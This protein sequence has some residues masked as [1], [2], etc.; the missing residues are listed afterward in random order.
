MLTIRAAA[1]LLAR[2]DSLESVRPLLRALGFEAP[3]HVVDAALR[4]ALALGDVVQR[5]RLVAGAGPLRALLAQL[6]DDADPREAARRIAHVLDRHA[7]GAAWLLALVHTPHGGRGHTFTLA[8]IGHASGGAADRHATRPRGPALRVQALRVQLDHVTDSDAD[9]LRAMVDAPREDALLTYARWCDLLGRDALSARFYRA[10]ERAVHTLGASAQGQGTGEERRTLALLTTSRLLFLSFL[11]AKGWLD[12]DRSFLLRE[13]TRALEAGGQ[14]HRRWLHP[15]CFGTLNTPV[16]QR[17]AAAQRFGRVP[18]LNGGLF[19]R[20]PLEGRLRT[21]TFADDALVALVGDVLD[22]YHFTAHEQASGWSE[23]AIDPEMLGR[24]FESLMVPAERRGSGTYYTPPALVERVVADALDVALP[25]GGTPVERRRRLEGLR[26]LDPACGS[27]AFLVH[28][29]ERLATLRIAAGDTRPIHAVRYAVLTESIFGVDRNPVAVWLCEL[30]LWLAVVLE[31]DEPDPLRVA[32]LPNLD[33]H[34]RVGDSLTGGDFRFSPAAGRRLAALRS[35]YVQAVGARKARLAEALDREERARARAELAR[36]ITHDRARRLTLLT[37]MR[38]RDLF[39]ERVP[40]SHADRLHLAQL[41]TRLRDLRA[42]DRRLA[43]GGALPFRFASHMADV[44]QQGGFDLVLGNPPWVRPHQLPVAERL[45]LRRDFRTMRDA[46]WR[47]GAARAGAGPGFA[48]QADLAAAFIERGVGLLRPGGA[49]AL[50]VPAKLWRSLAGGGVRRFLAEVTQLHAVTDW[51]DARALFDAAT[52]PSLIVVQR[53]GPTTPM[54]APAPPPAHA[55]VTV[56][57]GTREHRFILP[58]VSLPLGGDPGAPWL[59]L[60]PTV[61]AAFERLR[62][63]GPALGDA[64]LGRPTLGV[65]CGCNDAFLVRAHEDDDEL[66]RIAGGARGA[67]IERAL[68]R[69]ALTGHAIGRPLDPEAPC[70]IWTHGRDGRPLAALPPRAARWLHRWRPRLETRRDARQRQP[71]WTLFR[72]DAAR[73][74]TPRLVWAD[75]GRTLRTQVLDV[76]DPTVPLNTCYVL[77]T[78]SLDDAW[79][80]D[81]LLSSPLASAWLDAIAEPARGGWRR[82]LAWTVAALPI[83]ADWLR[84]R[85]LLAPLGRRRAIG[86]PASPDEHLAIVVAAYQLDQ[87]HVQPLLAWRHA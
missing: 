22:R 20:T 17:A 48:A 87:R 52:Y 13:C 36:M 58:P 7:T 79:A 14:L 63:Q 76:G 30:R 61:R 51:S 55:A 21:V 86:D 65:K 18:F 80:L 11:E 24:A 45:A 44:G 1:T 15:L 10:L 73:P 78:P 4:S 12:G 49:A 6:P 72:T 69:P 5:A 85:T 16:A 39:G 9:T 28:A 31:C 77:R 19:A 83:P 68:L 27:G 42:R 60:P 41:R 33:H 71:W 57:R 82:F 75:F 26:C 38:A 32:P 67:M 70:I 56:V 62:R 29:L 66:A 34:V 40:P 46:P 35:R 25:A 47:V 43:D 54:P 37:R 8:T 74:D 3:P 59:L 2:I 84:A 50:L 64:G 81:A 53:T 23:A